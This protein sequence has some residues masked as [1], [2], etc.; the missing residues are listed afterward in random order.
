MKQIDN[1]NYFIDEF[2]NVYNKDGHKMKP[3]YSNK[4]YIMFKLFI[5]KGYR[6]WITAHRIVAK[7]WVENKDNK[8]QV[9]HKDRNKLNNHYSNLEW[10]TNQ[11]NQDH[12][13]NN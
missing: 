4:G 2:G 12:W 7:Y 1:T 8:P 13:R 11:E 6:K 5:S 3:S 9:N 10:V